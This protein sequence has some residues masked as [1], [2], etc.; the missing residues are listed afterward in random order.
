MK[1][2]LLFLA[3]TIS[4][5]AES[6]F[7]RE[8]I[9]AG[10]QRERESSAALEPINR[11]YKESLESLLRRATQAGDLDAAIKI[12]EAI[13]AVDSTARPAVASSA[14]P[15]NDSSSKVELTK[16]GLEKRLEKTT[17]VTPS[18]NWCKKLLIEDG[19]VIHNPNDKGQGRSA[20]FQALDGSTIAFQ[21]D[22]KPMTITFSPDLSTCMRGNITYK[23]E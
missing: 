1:Y 5:F 18:N 14:P 21:W 17:W 16:R 10:E 2:L 11:R 4:A 19:K 23:R 9:K 20:R 3:I 13:A 22:G 7:E 6:A 12:R 15:A 8:L